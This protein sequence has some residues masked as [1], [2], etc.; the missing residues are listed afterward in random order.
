MD[1]QRGSLSKKIWALQGKLDFVRMGEAAK[2]FLGTHDFTS[3]SYR[4]GTA[5]NVRQVHS[6][7]IRQLPSPSVGSLYRVRITANGFLRKMV[8]LL[9]AGM[10]EVGLGLT[11]VSELATKLER[12]DPTEAPHPAPPCGLYLES[13][14]YAPDPFRFTFFDSAGRDSSL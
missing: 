3:F 6:A 11:D 9:V 2:L 5:G 14:E 13:V 8:R 1:E 4:C 12:Q 7:K 10:V